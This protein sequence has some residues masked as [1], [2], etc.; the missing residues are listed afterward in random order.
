M[1]THHTESWP[2]AVQKLNSNSFTV[3]L[4]KIQKSCKAALEKIHYTVETA[5]EKLRNHRK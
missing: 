2:N 3:F 4:E 1:N 5:D